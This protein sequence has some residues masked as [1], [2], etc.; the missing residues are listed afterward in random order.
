MLFYKNKGS[1]PNFIFVLFKETKQKSFNSSLELCNYAQLFERT[2]TA[3]HRLWEPSPLRTQGDGAGRGQAAWRPS[4]TP[5]NKV[6]GRFPPLTRYGALRAS[7][8]QGAARV[9]APWM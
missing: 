6:M 2:F 5:L 8:S 1:V 7:M 9:A 3:V 4:K